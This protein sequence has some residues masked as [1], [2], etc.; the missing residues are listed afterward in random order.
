MKKII[1]ILAIVAL[2][3]V[4]FATTMTVHTTNG[5][6]DFEISEITSITFNGP[7]PSDYPYL[8]GK[9]DE[10]GVRQIYKA[11]SDFSDQIALTSYNVS[12]SI[13]KWTFDGKI[14]FSRNI[15]TGISEL[16]L[17][18]ANG[19]NVQVIDNDGE[20]ISSLRTYASKS[21]VIY[22]KHSNGGGTEE[23]W[24]ANL[25]EPFNPQFL[26]SNAGDINDGASVNPSNLEEV[27]FCYD[28]GNWT[29]NRI[30]KVRNISTGN[31]TTLMN[32]NGMAD[33]NTFWGPSGEWLYWSENEAGHTNGDMTLKRYNI[34]NES[35]ETLV[36]GSYSNCYGFYSTSHIF[37]TSTTS[38]SN[39]TFLMMEL[40]GSNQ[41]VLHSFDE[42]AT[43]YDKQ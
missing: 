41:V 37:C 9:N 20:Y 24:T 8:L 12:S 21:K 4:I 27:A 30:I 6:V 14:V 1:I 26:F 17:M 2:F 33:F 32:S 43:L 15:G 25:S 35:I 34:G 31:E 38:S 5:N 7:N 11:N 36:D 42:S 16:A 39:A 40:D 18:D 19:N 28:S 22:C 13:A 23:I 10:D 29:P 3:S